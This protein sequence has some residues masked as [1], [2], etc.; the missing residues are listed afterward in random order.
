MGLKLT[1]SLDRDIREIDQFFSDL[2]FKIITKSARQALNRAASRTR[3]LAIKEIRRRRKLK[4]QDLKG[5]KKKGKKG[6]VTVRKAKGSNI[7]ALEAQVNFSGI[8]LPLILFILGDKGPKTQTLPN[9]RR[10]SRRFEIIKGKKKAKKGLFIQRAQRGSMTFQVFRREDPSDKSKG[11]T[12]QSAPSVAE[13]LRTKSNVLRKIENG[14]I[15][16]M[17]REYDRALQ[18]NLSKLKL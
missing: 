6:F 7:A 1:I 14:A 3:S 18:F 2:R 8:P 5:S 12:M 17:Q 4:L 9:Q 11:F 10:R 13:I 15:A 16:I